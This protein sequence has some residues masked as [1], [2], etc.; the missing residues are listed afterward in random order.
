MARLTAGDSALAETEMAKKPGVRQPKG[1][2]PTKDEILR[3]MAQAEGKVGKRE[4]AG[5]RKALRK[6]GG[7]PEVAVLEIVARDADGELLAEPAD[8]DAPGDRPRARID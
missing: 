3:F 2:V 6:R 7:L 8:W 5:A 1:G 4:I